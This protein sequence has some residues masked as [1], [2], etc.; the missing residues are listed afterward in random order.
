MISFPP[1]IALVRCFVM[2]ILTLTKTVGT[3]DWGTAVT[4]LT[5]LF[6]GGLWKVF[7]TLD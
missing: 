7:G 1:H 3:R 5:M 2:A 6:A 4:D